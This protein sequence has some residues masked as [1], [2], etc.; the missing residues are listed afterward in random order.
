MA[1]LLAEVVTVVM[2]PRFQQMRLLDLP[3]APGCMSNS[4]LRSKITTE[5]LV[6]AE[7]EAEASPEQLHFPKM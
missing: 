5:L 4:Q 6:V 1:L 2:E 7:A 3:V